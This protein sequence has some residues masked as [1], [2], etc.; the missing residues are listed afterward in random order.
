M[1]GELSP[2]PSKRMPRQGENPQDA[3]AQ[4]QCNFKP[5]YCQVTTFQAAKHPALEAKCRVPPQ[6]AKTK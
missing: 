5:Q 4:P 1:Q 3:N 2:S 6:D